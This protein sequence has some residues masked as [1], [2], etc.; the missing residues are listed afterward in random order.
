MVVANTGKTAKIMTGPMHCL[1]DGPLL[2][3]TVVSN[4]A[5]MTK[6]LE[7]FPYGLA[8]Y[9]TPAS[10]PCTP[11]PRRA[12]QFHGTHKN[13]VPGWLI[14]WLTSVRGLRAD[15][16]LAHEIHSNEHSPMILIMNKIHKM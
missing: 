8:R 3:G 15:R 4:Y 14:S 1:S 12:R 9:C 10:P 7:C 16:R 13:A 5:R 2:T 11:C 6:G